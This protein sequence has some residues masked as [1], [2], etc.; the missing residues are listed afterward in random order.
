LRGGGGLSRAAR[1]SDATLAGLPPA[2]ARPAYDRAAAR[3]GVVH[4]GPGAFHRGHQAFVLDQLLAHDPR[5][6]ICAVSLHSAD[7][8]DALAPQ[9]GL[10]TLAELD[11]E[12]RLRVIGSIKELLVAP[13]APAALLAR[14]ADPAVRL[15]TLTITEKGYALDAGGGLDLSH[16]DIVRD[17]TRMG[18]PASAL[19]WLL[20]G[21]EA[22]R[23]AGIAA[24]SVVSCDNLAANGDKLRGALLALARARGEAGL[25][26]WI[27]AEAAFPNTMVDSITPATDEALRQR[28][29]TALGVED[30]WPVQRERFWQ[31]VVEDR[32]A[33]GA[34]DLA[35]VG[36]TLTGDVGPFERAKLRLLNAAHSTLAYVGLLMGRETVFEAMGEARLAAFVERM[37]REDAAPT[38]PAAAGLD[39]QAYVSATLARFRNPAVRHQLIQIAADGS[40]KLANR[41]VPVLAERR[42]AG[43]PIGRLATPLAA[44]MVFIRGQIAAGAPI[45]DPMAARLAALALPDDPGEAVSAFLAL[46]GPLSAD[47]AA[48]SV[49]REAIKTAYRALAAGNFSAALGA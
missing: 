12:P 24:P 9:D 25:A 35:S 46:G 22:R 14:L 38:V 34:P 48:D 10:Y 23:G 7:V 39:P 6:G 27:E 3:V 13:E 19:G 36:V 31:W 42:A 16:P 21:L 26:G 11:A 30:A 17:L 49:V 4:L 37:M 43:A 1:L 15:I 32:L 29:R 44:W 33:P 41:I 2:V 45:A 18:R 20:A 47:L 40:A 8:R 28:V 5:W